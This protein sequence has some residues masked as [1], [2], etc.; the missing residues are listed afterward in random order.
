MPLRLKLQG[1]DAP[2]VAGLFACL[3]SVN[4]M[5]ENSSGSDLGYE[6]CAPGL[7]VFVSRAWQPSCQL[8]A[9]R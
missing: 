8:F 3:S 4:G 5:E 2:G 6:Y 7:R 1:G 9:R